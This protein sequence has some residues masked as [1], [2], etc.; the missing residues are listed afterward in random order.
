M[1]RHCSVVALPWAQDCCS[2]ADRAILGAVLQ[3]VILLS[4]KLDAA[5]P[6]KLEEPGR[7]MA[8]GEQG[9][10]QLSSHAAL[11]R[12]N[13]GMEAAASPVPRAGVHN[14][15]SSLLCMTWGWFFSPAPHLPWLVPSCGTTLRFVALFCKQESWD[16]DKTQALQALGME[17]LPARSEKAG[18]SC[19]SSAGSRDLPKVRQ[20]R[21]RVPAPSFPSAHGLGVEA[22]PVSAPAPR[23][24]GGRQA[25]A[26][27][28]FSGLG[29][30]LCT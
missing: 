30:L 24:G 2:Q 4:D 14:A 1:V 9:Q 19:R 15:A 21:Q 5:G 23:A 13:T 10:A 7:G 3:L 22:E 26:R 8:W 18:D 12:I 17:Q 27:L 11:G 25:P 28:L 6:Q 16:R 20:R 29:E